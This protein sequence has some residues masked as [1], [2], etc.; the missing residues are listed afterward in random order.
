MTMIVLRTVLG[1]LSRISD[2]RS[3]RLIDLIVSNLLYVDGCESHRIVTRQD[4]Q[5]LILQ[6]VT[7]EMGMLANES[8]SMPIEYPP[9]VVE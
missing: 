2:K 1:K 5:C 3:A 6:L 8:A 7:I 9:V 4:P